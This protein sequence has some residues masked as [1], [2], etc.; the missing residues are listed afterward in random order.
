MRIMGIDVEFW[1]IFMV[2]FTILTY[3][4]WGFVVAFEVVLGMSGS[5][6]AL[7]WIKAHHSYKNLYIETIIFY[8][9]ILLGYFFLEWLPHLLF[10]AH[11]SP[12]DLQALF[13]EV[14]GSGV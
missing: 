9:M 5:K 6:L 14:F 12:F 3:L 10:K 8:P 4:V 2:L 1:L 11:L 7:R 13:E